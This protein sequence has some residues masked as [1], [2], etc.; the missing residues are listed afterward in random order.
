MNF[1]SGHMTDCIVKEG[2]SIGSAGGG[3]YLYRAA[4]IAEDSQIIDNTAVIAPFTRT[5]F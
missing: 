3:I 4:F 5:H 2:E 1:G